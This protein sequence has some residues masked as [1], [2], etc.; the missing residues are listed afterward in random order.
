MYRFELLTPS[1]VDN[2]PNVPKT[3]PRTPLARWSVGSDRPR[4]IRHDEEA[5]HE[6][7]VKRPRGGLGTCP[8]DDFGHSPGCIERS[9]GGEDGP[10]VFAV[11]ADGLHVIGERFIRTS[12]SN[13]F[14]GELEQISV[15]PANVLLGEVDRIGVPEDRFHHGRIA[16][17]LL[18]VA[19]GEAPYVEIREQMLDIPVAQRGAFDPSG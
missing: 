6:Q 18:L 7:Q 9:G 17:D 8:A 13:A 11:G 3:D 12:V 1:Y 14:L 5:D 19:R 15:E 16:R 4:S 10:E 2:E